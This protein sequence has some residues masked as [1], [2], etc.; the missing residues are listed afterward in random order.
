MTGAPAEEARAPLTLEPLTAEAFEPFGDVIEARGAFHPINDG[1]CDRFHDLARL[2]FGGP[3]GR[4]MISIGRSRP[5][6]LPYAF[7][8]LERHPLGSQCFVPLRPSPYLVI[9]APDEG[10]APGR[11]RAFRAEGQ[12]VNYLKGVWHGVLA[13]LERESDFLIVDRG[14]DGVNL[15]ERRVAPGYRVLAPV[16][17]DPGEANLRSAG[18]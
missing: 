14:G 5:V 13:P 12:G 3:N 6:R 7:D 2:E 18:L 8:L 10:D 16:D 4:A 15:E 1:R 11:P 9:V 17:P